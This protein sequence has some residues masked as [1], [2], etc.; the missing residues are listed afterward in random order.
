MSKA[1]C[2][3]RRVARKAADSLINSLFVLGVFGAFT[4]IVMGVGIGLK[5]FITWLITR[6]GETAERAL[7]LGAVGVFC[8]ALAVVVVTE[9]VKAVREA[10]KCCEAEWEHDPLND[11]NKVLAKEMRNRLAEM[12]HDGLSTTRCCEDE[13]GQ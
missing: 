10:A 13:G 1:T 8:L 4:V 6:Y 7:G 2:I 12:L 3:M 11:V 5:A 9:L